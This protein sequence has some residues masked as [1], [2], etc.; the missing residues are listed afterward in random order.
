MSFLVFAGCLLLSKGEAVN[1]RAV[2][3]ERYLY[4]LC[5]YRL[6]GDTFPNADVIEHRPQQQQENV[7]SSFSGYGKKA[8]RHF[9]QVAVTLLGMMMVGS[10]FDERS[11]RDLQVVCGIT[12]HKPYFHY[13]LIEHY[14]AKTKNILDSLTALIPISNL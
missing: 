6:N 2:E 11:E 5:A 7:F 10:F 12:F 3:R 4:C 13:I 14:I 9:D 8:E 1:R